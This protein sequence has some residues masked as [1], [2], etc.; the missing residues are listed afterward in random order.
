MLN[1][2]SRNTPK[3]KDNFIIKDIEAVDGFDT[4]EIYAEDNKIVLAGSS[5][6]AKAMA[7]YRYLGDF[8]SV[9]I[10]SGDYD[11]ST[12]GTSPL[13][14][15]KITHTVRQ[16]I[17]ARMSY[18]M[19]SLQGNFWGF[20]RWQK[21][22]DFMV[23]NGIN[24]ALQ[25]V[26]FDGVMYKMLS[27]IGLDDNVS[28]EYSSGPAFL[29]RQLTGNIAS[30]NAVMSKTYLERKVVL[31]RMITERMKEVGI[32]PVLPAAL[33]S[34]PFSLRRKAIKMEI[35]KAPM[36]YNFPPIFFIKPENYYYVYFNNKFLE[37]QKRL[38]GETGSYFFEPLYD[39]NPKGFTSHL[40]Q[41]G[42][43]LKALLKLFCENAVCYTH[44]GSISESFF[45]K[46]SADGFIIIDDKNT[47]ETIEFLKDKTHLVAITGNRYGRTG[48]YGNVDKISANP[49]IQRKAQTDT[50]LGTAV[51][52]DTFDENPMYCGTV[53]HALTQNDSFNADEFIR[54]F[55]KK[56]YKTDAY[57]DKLIEL[58]NLCNQD[59]CAGSIICARP[60]TNVKHTA[61]Y[62]SVERV[63][64][65]KKLYELADSIF[66][67][68]ERKI[69]TMRADL[70]SIVRQFLSELAYPVYKAATS[71]FYDGNVGN[72]EQA[73]NLF[74]E[75][76]EDMDRLLKTRKETCFCIKYSD[77]QELGDTNEEK[78]AIQI[79]YLMLHTIWGP[80]DHS[81]LYDTV[82]N[83]WA[84]LI[85]DY[86]EGRW[87]MYFRSLAAYFSTP[88]KLKDN[89]KKQPLDRN[90]YKGSY[91]AKRLAFFEDDFLEGYLPK[92]DGVE[93][94]DTIE[95]CKEILEKYAE[96]YKQF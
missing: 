38:I 22:I 23:M 16:K 85:K 14:E 29:M 86:Y 44:V 53:L 62:D 77:A 45:K 3:I 24:T 94:E 84:G 33:P 41:T 1:L 76:C 21:E 80:F 11:I 26:G 87:H 28:L 20:D 93:E 32:E 10:T 51:N 79:N 17:R 82:W 47:P 72:F 54:S 15:E 55:C 58:K 7:Y 56:R 74:L 19:F 83:E 36:W 57:S 67:T 34:V 64:D 96:V 37:V 18:E 13:P 8:C 40:E 31:G 75:I 88:K 6:C 4:Y 70:Q 78:E 52:L 43:A 39:V 81:V 50:V 63:I 30:T 91:Q 90:E 25:P 42:A 46:T 92:K 60:C 5:P 49:Y 12:L 48:I 95:V 66:K 71:F 61:P 9:V 27:E 69:D 35:F 65:F 68:D 59:E 73:S 2:I 89:S